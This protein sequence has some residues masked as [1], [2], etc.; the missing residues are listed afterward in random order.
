MI[1]NI[2]FDLDVTLVNTVGDLTVATNTMR[3]HLGLN[4]ES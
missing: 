3:K 2:F 4:P 1:K